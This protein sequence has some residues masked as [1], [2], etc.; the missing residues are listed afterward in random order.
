MSIDQMMSSSSW[1]VLN[2][3]GVA[4]PLIEDAG[5]TQGRLMIS[6]IFQAPTTI[7]LTTVTCSCHQICCSIAPRQ[8]LESTGQSNSPGCRPVHWPPEQPAHR[9]PASPAGAELFG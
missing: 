7:A 4:S 6:I 8:K 9:H 3:C 1:H 5:K 2:V